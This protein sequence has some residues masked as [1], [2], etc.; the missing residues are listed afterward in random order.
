MISSALA[1]GRLC[2]SVHRQQFGRRR[3]GCT[4]FGK[5]SGWTS[6]DLYPRTLADV[7]GDGK[8]DVVGFGNRGVYYFIF[9]RQ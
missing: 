4:R 7:N 1:R 3:S 9:Y 2:V 8:S 5:G 6:Q